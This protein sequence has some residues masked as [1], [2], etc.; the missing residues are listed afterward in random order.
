MVK[1][2]VE[3]EEYL[4]DIKGFLESLGFE[5]YF[6]EPVISGEEGR[7]NFYRLLGKHPEE[8][9]AFCLCAGLDEHAMQAGH[10]H[11]DWEFAYCPFDAFDKWGNS[12]HITKTFFRKPTLEQ[13]KDSFEMTIQINGLFAIPQEIAFVELG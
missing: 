1:D 5:F 7:T 11:W 3:F 6:F 2:P 4:H 12:K 13:I 10:R 8:E 9:L